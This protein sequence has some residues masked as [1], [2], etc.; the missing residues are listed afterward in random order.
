[1]ATKVI[2]IILNGAT[3]RIGSTQ[4]LAN[5]LVPIRDEGGL[6]VGDDRIVP[7][8]LL[9]G[10]DAD[11][12]AS[13]AATHKV[14]DWTTN[15]DA[16]LGAADVAVLFDAAAPHQRA[17]ALRKAVAAG[18]HIYSE[19]PVASSVAEGR[20]LL[21]AIEARGLKHGAVE[22]KQYL[23]GLRKLA[24]VVR[25]GALGR[26]VS[27]R[28]EFG[29]WVFDG[30]DRPGQRP[31]WNYRR[32]GG[33]GLILD[34]YPHWRYVI[35]NIVGRIARVVSV[36]TTAIPERVDEQGARYAVDV[37]DHAATLVELENGAVGTI[38]SSWV[39]R[40]RRDDLLVLQVDGTKGSAVAGLHRCAV[41]ADALTPTISHFNI[42]SDIG[43]DYR[44]DWTQAG[45][46]GA[47]RNPYRVGWE[48]FLRHVVAGTPL[49]SDLAA[50]IRD[51]QLAEACNRS[52]TEKR[53]VGLG[54]P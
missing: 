37:E 23:P 44:N 17:V 5:A 48:D 41:Q 11:K 14:A 30:S 34:M 19:K 43:P 38:L 40:V 45:D 12:L 2:G 27:F 33:G 46:V 42:A 8:P 4:H 50:G 32:A 13:I 16:A 47:Y 9:V 49:K 35:E 39:T 28:L 1:M 26:I 54:D 31:S 7:R 25:S 36:S 15:L 3:G 24:H 51:V 29:W 6:V 52:M 22:D 18:K 21:R 20:A 53:W 10:R